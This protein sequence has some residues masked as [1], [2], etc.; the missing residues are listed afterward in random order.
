MIRTS[1]HDS[2]VMTG[3]GASRCLLMSL[4]A[5][6]QAAL[7]A[8]AERPVIRFQPQ[9]E[10]VILYQPAAI[11]V[12]AGG[13]APLRYQWYKDNLPVHG[14]TND[15]IVFS[16][17]RFSDA[18]RFSV[19]V[20]N[21][22]G[23][24]TSSAARLSVV[25][26][27]PGSLDA[28]FTGG[29][30][31]IHSIMA[32]ALQPDGKM[33][34]ADGS[35]RRLNQDGSTD[36]TFR[37]A[38]VES[39][40]ATITAIAVQ[41]DG[42]ILVGGYQV[43]VDPFDYCA[44][45]IAVAR[46]WRLNPDGSPDAGFRSESAGGGP[47]PQTVR[48]AS[49]TG[50]RLEENCGM[51]NEAA[52]PVHSVVLQNDGRLLVGGSFSS[53]QGHA[54]SS[55]NLARL[56][57]DGTPDRTFQTELS[58]ANEAIYSIALQA[59]GK[60]LI[61]GEFTEVHGVRC[62]RIARL[63]SDGTLDNSFIGGVSINESTSSYVHSITVQDDGRALIGGFFRV[64]NGV[65]RGGIARL[66]ADGSLDRSFLEGLSGA[67][68]AV[69]GA[70]MVHAIAVQTDGKVLF[71]GNF[72]SV[73]GGNRLRIARLNADGSL[74][75]GYQH[76][77]AGVG[78]GHSIYVNSI[79]VG[80]QD[81]KA[82]IAGNFAS[83]NGALRRGIARLNAD[84]SLDGSFQSGLAGTLGGLGYGPVNA[85]APQEDG[86]IVIGGGFQR[87]NGETRHGLA[88]LDSNGRIDEAF[89]ALELLEGSYVSSLAIER[90]GRILVGGWLR[91]PGIA[92]P[93]AIA[94]LKPD[95]SRDQSFSV[96]GLGSVGSIALQRDGSVVIAGGFSRVNGVPVPG[97]ARL[98][99]TADLEPRITSLQRNR[100]GT[101]LTWDA[102]PG[103]E[104]RVRS[105][106]DLSAPDWADLPGETPGSVQ[107][108]GT[109]GDP[110]ANDT[111]RRLYCVQLLR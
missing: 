68:N 16:H 55:F 92:I 23:N 62:G 26:P 17:P 71:A 50:P 8:M 56:N 48:L 73:N 96:E 64:V 79:A 22:E 49:R 83:V 29:E 42:K 33:L 7:P 27:G 32:V 86:R 54:Q 74:D 58:G 3:G 11:G 52:A 13:T 10:A 78:G 110:V 84:G 1:Q 65:P 61:G 102:L 109:K 70:G 20:F 94:R 66:N 44:G 30:E 95:G 46:V 39:L 80:G 37:N 21:E 51:S 57:S 67:A 38:S 19:V 69:Y 24:V 107:G 104:Y 93:C 28:S 45:T 108:I 106:R 35:V 87:V 18:G 90:D 91:V 85:V 89:A 82:V 103:R 43:Y 111:S 34:I 4:L 14:A 76:E 2:T 63:H 88:R 98:W 72:E 12:I 99:G 31:P 15:Q 53:F 77:L 75:T 41:G 40:D 6:N 47:P 60:V 36:R 25:A 9:E 101:H 97:I 81:G 5:L 105:P 59:D 100:S